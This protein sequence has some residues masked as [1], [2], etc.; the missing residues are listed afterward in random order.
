VT[1]L[2]S[3]VPKQ[4]IAVLGSI[5]PSRTDLGLRN[6]DQAQQV[7][8]EMG[9]ALADKGCGVVVYSSDLTFI[10]PHIVKGYVESGK[11]TDGSIRVLYSRRMVKPQ[12]PEHQREARC[13]QFHIDENESWEVSFYR[14]LYDVDGLIL[15]GGGQSTF[16]AGIIAT[17]RRT[18]LIVL[19]GF[20]GSAS[21]VWELLNP[22]ECPSVLKEEK[23]AM[24][25]VDASPAWANR[26]VAGLLAQKDRLA[27][28]TRD[29]EMQRQQRLRRLLVRA[30]ASVTVLVLAL[31]L[32]VTTWDAVLKRMVLLGA[33]ISAPAL[34]GA[35]ASMVRSL[36]E[37]VT[38]E[39]D[40]RERPALITALLGCSAG[41]IAGLLYIVAQLTTLTPSESGTM[42]ASASRLVPFALLTGFLAG[43]ATDAF[44]RKMR[45]R[46]VGSIEVPAFRG[47][48]QS[49]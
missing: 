16:A 45:D 19:D 4:W 25:E 37:E 49:T 31:A 12:F 36:W 38:G 24:A 35:A 18:P 23:S 48:G 41:I 13:F 6:L 10:E 33:L 21:R 47:P 46:D 8:H 20:G 11:A 5:D 32:F 9:R 22:S 34:A 17:T 28:A 44:F 26:M 7:L 1:I 3:A 39:T 43:F 14:S 30:F 27:K 2:E 29:Q 42:P 15:M 40:K